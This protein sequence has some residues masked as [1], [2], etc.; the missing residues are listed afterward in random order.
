MKTVWLF[1]D[2]GILDQQ[3]RPV[4]GVPFQD[5]VTV[6]APHQDQLAVIVDRHQIWIHQDGRWE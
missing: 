4:P 2:T 5:P 3:A 6:G 1:S